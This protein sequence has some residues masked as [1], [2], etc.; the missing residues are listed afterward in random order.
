MANYRSL[1]FGICVVLLCSVA[2]ADSLLLI[3]GDR[4]TGK[5]GQLVDGKLTFESD[6]A[7][8][9]TIDIANVA[10][11]SS[12]KTIDLHLEDGS[13]LQKQVSA[14][15]PNHVAIGPDQ[16]IEFARIASINPPPKPK[17]KWKGDASAGFA[18][19]AGN[20]STESITASINAQKRTEKDRRTVSGDFARSRTENPNTGKKSRSE[21]WWRVRTKYDYFFTKKLYGYLDGRYEVDKIAQIDPRMILGAGGGYQWIESEEMNFATEAGLAYKIEEYTNNTSKSEEIAAQLG[22]NFDKKIGEKFKFIHD[23]TY[24]P[25]TENLS[26]YF[27]TTTAELR[28]SINDTMFTNFKAVLDYDATPAAGQHK[29]DTK[30]IWGIGWSF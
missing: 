16:R 8:E 24:Y 23:L 1:I 5:I 12:D 3:N 21:D 17:P 19:T 7:G 13:V 28:A 29:T 6:L 2:G 14:S 18:S 9:L 27:L 30:Y 26:D 20:T 22:Y 15:E 10:T 25:S 4:L 11:F